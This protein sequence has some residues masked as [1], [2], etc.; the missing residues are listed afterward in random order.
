MRSCIRFTQTI[1]MDISVTREYVR[2]AIRNEAEPLWFPRLAEPLAQVAWD[3]LQREIGLT[4]NSYGTTRFLLRDPEAEHHIAARCR[5]KSGQEWDG[6]PGEI[7][8]EILAADIVRQITDSEVRLLNTHSV[9][10]TVFQQ[11][12]EALSLL[13]LVPTVWRTVRQL[14]RAL[15]VIDP[16]DNDTDVSFSD[17]MVPFS[18]FV[19]VPPTQS[20]IAVLRIAEAILHE[21]MHL[22]LTLIGQVVPLVLPERMMYYSPWRDE[23]RDSEGMLQALYVFGVIRSFWGLV[24]AR[25][26]AEVNHYVA[27]RRAHIDFQIGQA[28]QFRECDELTPDGTALV[29]RLFDSPG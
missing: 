20:G 24:P 3:R 10:G 5:P 6:G 18:V 7:P 22:H 17:P 23:E 25:R 21:S 29:A 8:V 14:V 16:D 13:D 19:S 15:H 1:D 11:L 12:D 26:S 28:Q 9:A 2:T 4:P 27:E